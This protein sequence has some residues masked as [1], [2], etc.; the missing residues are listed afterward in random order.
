M[1]SNCSNSQ[2]VSLVSVGATFE[3]PGVFVEVIPGDI[4]DVVREALQ[5]GTHIGSA[6]DDACGYKTIYDAIIDAE[7][8]GAS[9]LRYVVPENLLFIFSECMEALDREYSRL[10]ATM[11]SNHKGAGSNE[12]V[13]SPDNRR[14]EKR[15]TQPMAVIFC[16]L[17]KAHSLQ[18]A[19]R[20]EEEQSAEEG[21]CQKVTWCQLQELKKEAEKLGNH[22]D[23][24]DLSCGAM[25]STTLVP[26]EKTSFHHDSQPKTPL[27]HGGRGDPGTGSRFQPM[28]QSPRHLC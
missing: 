10:V 3:Q 16:K 2:I 22:R 11:E 13:D 24:E 14:E 17:K 5:H 7:L 4:R 23:R 25:N 19:F 12:N 20:K 21:D 18:G 9:A 26:R 8:I 27:A 1:K 6:I 15:N 28:K